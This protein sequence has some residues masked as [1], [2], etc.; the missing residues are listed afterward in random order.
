MRRPATGQVP[1]GG[2]AAVSAC[3]K[4]VPRWTFTNPHQRAGVAQQGAL[5]D[6]LRIGLVQAAQ[7]V[8]GRLEVGGRDGDR[9]AA[10]LHDEVREPSTAVSGDR[11]QALTY[12]CR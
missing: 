2:P 3:E 9:S 10:V 7:R 12:A 8:R 5:A 4:P 11:S 1:G 6:G